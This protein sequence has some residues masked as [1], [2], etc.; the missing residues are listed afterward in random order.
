MAFAA[1][2]AV[3]VG[4]GGLLS[5]PRAS[6]ASGPTS[7]S[8]ALARSSVLDTC[9]VL[10]GWSSDNPLSLDTA[11]KKEGAASIAMTGTGTQE[12]VRTFVQPVQTNATEAGGSLSF[13]YYVQD[14]A[15][16]AGGEGSVELTSSGHPDVDEYAWDMST[17]RAGVSNGWNH[18]TLRFSD[19]KK[20]G[21]PNLSAVNFFR[22][23]QFTNTTVHAKIDDLEVQEEIRVSAKPRVMPVT[24]GSDDVPV[25]SYSVL[26]W[27]A[28]PNDDTDDTQAFQAAMDAANQVGGAAVFVPAGRYAIRGNLTVPAGVTLRG[29]WRNPDNGGLGHGTVLMA[30]AGRDDPTGSAFITTQDG[31]TVRDLTVWYPEQNDAADVHA[32]PWTVQ[33]DPVDGYYGPNLFDLTFVNAYQGVSINQNNGHYLRQ[34]YGTFL[35]KGISIDGVYDIGRLETI[36]AGPTYWAQSGLP[37]APSVSTVTAY[38]RSHATAVT[39]Y[40][41]DWEYIYDVQTDGY[42]I[43]VLAAKSAK[44][45]FNGQI[46]KLHTE[47][48]K[49]GLQLDVVSDIGVV[50][51]A[52]QLDTSGS[53]GVSVLAGPGFAGSNALSVSDSTLSSPDGSLVVLQGSGLVN[54]ANTEFVDWSAGGAAV[55]AEAGSVVVARST[56]AVAKPDVHLGPAVSSAVVRSNVYAGT[57]DITN[58][59]TGDVKVDTHPPGPGE[60][61]STTRYEPPYSGADRYPQPSSQALFDVTAYGAQGNGA[62]DDTSAFRTA[63]QAATRAGGGTVYVPAGRYRITGHLAVASGVELRGVSDGPH[64][65]GIAPRGSVLLASENE[66][67]PNGTPFLSLSGRAGVRGLSVFYPFQRY[68]QPHAYPTTIRGRGNGNYVVDVTLPDSYTGIELLGDDY[69]VDYARGMGLR[70]FMTVDRATGGVVA[71]AMNTVGDWQDGDRETNA[72]PPNWWQTNPSSPASG[73][74]LQDA[75]GTTLFDNFSFGMTYGLT[76]AG[77]SSDIEA[78]GH[79]VDNSARAIRL[80]GSGQGLHFVNTQLVAIGGG[81]KRYLATSGSFTGSAAFSN[82]LAWACPAGIELAGGGTVTFRQWKAMDGGVQQ[83]AG[84]MRLESSYLHGTTPQV[85]L[86][87]AIV[88]AAVI[89]NVGNT[90]G[91]V[92]DNAKGDPDVALNVRK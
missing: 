24:Q 8:P 27:G 90:A 56:F 89:G 34:L 61:P 15:T 82:T 5:G 12:F 17:I 38:L 49:V 48:G 4:S 36:H 85:Y 29:D 75:K 73:I 20:T 72:P 41:S 79:G 92:V 76:V 10:A 54:L 14:V 71:N 69:R 52:S 80:T 39:L 77:S 6:A 19:A 43:G 9:D 70:E 18:L 35:S 47:N 1:A 64:H 59:S 11:D 51:T 28:T 58:E 40:R 88:D 23:Y 81:E 7:L 91:F 30:F 2:G 55:R 87:P 45:V 26:D 44:G 60:G 78:Y 33:N 63:L 3:A 68:D 21:S 22:I 16:L 83:Y 74:R 84:T 53:D 42:Q 50:V 86:G 46:G 32:Y 31:A 57:P 66:G 62:D 13:W 67:K 37:G 25:A 65:Y